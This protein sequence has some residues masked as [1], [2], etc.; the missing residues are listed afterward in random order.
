M[1][2]GMVVTM[3]ILMGGPLTGAAV[4][5]ARAL[6]PALAAGH[7]NDWYVYW[8]GPIIGGLVAGILYNSLFYRFKAVP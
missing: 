5:P 2:I 4:N 6:G 8:I 7:L 1:A 3:D